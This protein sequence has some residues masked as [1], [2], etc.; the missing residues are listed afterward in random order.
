MKINRRY[1]Q[2]SRKR[3]VIAW[4]RGEQ[5]KDSMTLVSSVIEKPGNHDYVPGLDPHLLVKASLH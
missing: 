1:Q 2:K 3:A 4:R 5:G